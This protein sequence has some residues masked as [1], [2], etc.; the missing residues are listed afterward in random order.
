MKLCAFFADGTNNVGV[1]TSSGTVNVTALGFP[2]EMN[3]VIEGGFDM[4]SRISETLESKTFPTISEESLKFLPVTKP[5]KIICKGLNYGAHA[6]EIG[7]QPPENPVFFSKFSDSLAAHREPVTLPAWLSA[8]DH[9]AE[10]VVVM[11]KPAYNIC[12]EEAREHIFGYTCG[13]DL[14]ARK[15]QGLS[16]QWLCGKAIP[17]F[18]P[19]GPF[20]QTA[21]GFDP[22]EH[23]GVFCDLNGARAQ[24]GTTT[25]MIFDCF[26]IV[27]AASKFFPLS[28][29]DLIFTGTP[30]GVIVGRPKDKREWLK[31]GDTVDVTIEGIGTLTTP[32]V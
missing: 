30:A 23:H 6:K 2:S 9:E 19:V 13:N 1:K 28:P 26:E 16:G 10:L 8:F 17:G 29:G 12:V 3:E 14:S 5:A 11:G 27:S 32:L 15:A 7:A 25:D 24:S 18:A 22:C 21:D 4:L 31:P 20:I